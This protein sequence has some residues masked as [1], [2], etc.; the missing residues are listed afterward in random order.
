M[1]APFSCSGWQQQLWDILFPPRCLSCRKTGRWICENCR[2]NIGL[3]VSPICYKCQRLSEGFKVCDHCRHNLFVR[4]LIVCGYWQNP[5][6][7]LIYGMKYYK[8]RPLAEEL[9]QILTAAARNF[10]DQDMVIV[11]VPL[12]RARLWDRGFNQA[13]ILAKVVACQLGCQIV[14]P[15]RRKRFTKPQFNLTRSAR[16]ANVADAFAVNPRELPKIIHRIVVLV[17]DIVTTGATLN[18]CAKVLKQN[19]AREVWGLVLAKA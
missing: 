19:G 5:L 12:H 3:I 16:Q 15:L 14:A 4:R 1:S 17:D 18:A 11:P 8:V 2:Q 6:K 10:C 13:E 9:G 7:Q